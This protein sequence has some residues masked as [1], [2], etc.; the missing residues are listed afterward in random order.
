VKGEN[1]N[2]RRKICPIP[3]S[4][5]KNLQDLTLAQTWNFAVESR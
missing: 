3:T 4:S 1:R 5:A 2:T